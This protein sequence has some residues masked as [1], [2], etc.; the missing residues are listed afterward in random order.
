MTERPSWIT[1][2][3]SH[4]HYRAINARDTALPAPKDILSRRR[5]ATES[6]EEGH[7]TSQRRGPAWARS[8]LE[9]LDKE[10]DNP[11]FPAPSSAQRTASI[12][13][14]ETPAV[15]RSRLEK[16]PKAFSK[17]SSMSLSATS[18]L[19]QKQPVDAKTA[20]DI[21]LG[22]ILRGIKVF[23]NLPLHATIVK[24]PAGDWTELRY[25]EC[26]GNYSLNT[27]KSSNGVN[28]LRLHLHKSHTKDKGDLAS[29]KIVE[30]ST[31]REL[32]NEKLYEI[33]RRGEAGYLV[34]KVNSRPIT[35]SPA[36]AELLGGVWLHRSPSRRRL[37]RDHLPCLQRQ[38]DKEKGE[39]IEGGVKGFADHL[40]DWHGEELVQS[41][42]ELLA[43]IE[44]G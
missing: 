24:R 39:Y 3:P 21:E 27:K 1:S 25:S 41:P 16:Q 7:I 29:E 36:A 2:P 40:G 17:S 4:H 22:A 13:R 6:A 11:A 10:I 5:K 43:R 28:C 23:D 15:S 14:S 12:S 44:G 8:G 33:M 42:R 19:Y 35:S 9:T 34:A 31:F 20:N 38:L 32:S 18:N 30:T 26:K 37:G